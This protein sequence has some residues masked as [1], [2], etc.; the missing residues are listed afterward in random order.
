MGF[1]LD[2][3]HDDCYK[4][5]DDED[6]I[7]ALKIY[8]SCRSQ[9]CLGPE[10]LGPA[11]AAETTVLGD[12]HIYDGEVIDPPSNAATVS[13]DKLKIKKIMIVS[14]EESPFKRGYW[15]LDLKYV[16]EY[17]LTFRE[18]DGCKI[19]CVKANSIYNKRVTLFGSCGTESVVATDLLCEGES[20]TLESDPFVIV[21]GKAVALSA[22]L[23][24]QKRITI[25][26]DLPPEP[27]AVFVTIGLFTIIK[28]CRLVDL[29]V[30]T[31]GICIPEECECID[32]LSPCEFFDG[33]D[34]PIDAFTP[35]EKPTFCC[36]GKEKDE[37]PCGKHKKKK[38]DC[39]CKE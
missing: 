35:P 38:K 6:C 19:G 9:D 18:A 2:N 32:R 27:N 25:C 7:V 39:G 15:D 14:K 11:R 26:E 1:E 29:S 16:F 20:I 4:R 37:E 13:I 17:R 24:Y 8:D 33:L 10:I 21:E 22:E 36:G 23:K 5:H 30:E 3:S 12:E 31:K 28:L 34:F